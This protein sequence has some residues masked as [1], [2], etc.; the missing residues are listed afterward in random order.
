MLDIDPKEGKFLKLSDGE[1]GL[2]IR[3]QNGPFG[4]AANIVKAPAAPAE[5]KAA[6]AEKKAAPA[7][8]ARKFCTECGSKNEDGG[9][10]C[11]DCGKPF[12]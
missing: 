1:R 2:Q 4:V 6:P 12:P 10:F 5:K 9:R 7:P 8:G 11:S 3:Q